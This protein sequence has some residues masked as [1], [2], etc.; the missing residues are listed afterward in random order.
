M[1]KALDKIQT[2]VRREYSDDMDFHR[3]A[4][5]DRM[6]YF[7]VR[8][9][10]DHRQP[11]PGMETLIL[12]AQAAGLRP[13]EIREL[14]VETG[15]KYLHKLIGT[16]DVSPST[17]EQALVEASRKLNAATE[18][19]FW[20]RIVGQFEVLAEAARVDISREIQAMGV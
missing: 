20:S 19:K 3:R 14:L 6:A 16:A 10:F 18:G 13:A 5:G 1:K 4:V 8:R 2:R 7:T 15:D 12:L 17:R 11:A 9:C